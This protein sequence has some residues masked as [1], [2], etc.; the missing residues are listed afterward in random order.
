MIQCNRVSQGKR[1]DF[2]VTDV[3]NKEK[4]KREQT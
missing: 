3:N 2:C 1:M 4:S